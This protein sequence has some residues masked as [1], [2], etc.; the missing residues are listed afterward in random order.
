MAK[1]RHAGWELPKVLRIYSC[2]DLLLPLLLVRSLS[3]PS[4]TTPLS[5]KKGTSTPLNPGLLEEERLAA[6]HSAV[7][8]SLTNVM[9]ASI[10]HSYD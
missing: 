6:H 10:G 2:I 8:T 3:L 4:L 1:Q 9:S 5:K 7:F